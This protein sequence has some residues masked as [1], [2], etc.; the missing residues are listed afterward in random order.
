M[1]PERPETKTRTP[2]QMA[3]SFSDVN[4]SGDG[5][6]GDRRLPAGTRGQNRAAG[7]RYSE[8]ASSMLKRLP[9]IATPGWNSVSATRVRWPVLVVIS[10]CFS[11]MG[12]PEKLP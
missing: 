3:H 11:A 6:T 7:Q 10:H 5:E 12:S 8:A 1:P 4:R 9:L 2:A